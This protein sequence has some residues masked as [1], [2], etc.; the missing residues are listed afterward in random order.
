MTQ[1]PNTKVIM[2]GYSQG[3]QLVH[4]AAEQLPAD[5]TSRVAAAIIF[6]DPNN[7][8]P[9]QGVA[10]SKTQINCRVGDNICSG[11]TLILAP[12][13]AYGRDADKAAT[14]AA[15]AVRAA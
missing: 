6:G 3:G 13:L 1:C 14:F 9:V 15:Q 2:S 7:G 12:H 4:N 11:G 8:D 10:A 5:V